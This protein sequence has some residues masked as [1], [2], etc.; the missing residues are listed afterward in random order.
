M[1]EDELRELFEDVSSKALLRK[2]RDTVNEDMLA[3]EDVFNRLPTEINNKDLEQPLQLLSSIFTITEI[4]H[5]RFDQDNPYRSFI[6]EES[7]SEP[8][9]HPK[10]TNYSDT[11]HHYFSNVLPVHMGKWYTGALLSDTRGFLSV[12]DTSCKLI[13]ITLDDDEID[14]DDIATLLEIGSQTLPKFRGMLNAVADYEE[15]LFGEV[16]SS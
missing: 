12:V 4:L 16:E 13:E 8:I 15:Q 1:P 5:S 11:Y 7:I 9:L 2:F 14:Y 10:L 3:A 6:T